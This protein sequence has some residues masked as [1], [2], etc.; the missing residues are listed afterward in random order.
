VNTIQHA[1]NEGVRRAMVLNRPA[2][3]YG[4]SGNQAGTAQTLPACDPNT[5][6]GSVSCAAV[7]LAPSNIRVDVEVPLVQTTCPAQKPANAP[8]CFTPTENVPAAN[9]VSVTVHLEYYPLVAFPLKGQ[10]HMA[11]YATSQTQ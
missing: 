5:I 2:S 4:L 10:F 6:M 3:Q 11:G 1:A 9:R 7:L 8:P